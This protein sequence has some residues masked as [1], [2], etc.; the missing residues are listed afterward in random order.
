VSVAVHSKAY[1]PDIDTLRAVAVGSVL[2]FH[3][4]LPGVSGGYVGVDVF[5][6]ISGFLI[7][8]ILRDDPSIIRFYIR[9]AARI[10]PA[11]F[12]MLLVCLVVGYVILLPRDLEDLATSTLATLGFAS[13]ILFWQQSGYFATASE[14][15]PLLHTWSLAVEEQFYVLFPL[16]MLATR[17][18]ERRKVA[19]LVGILTVVSFLI[20]VYCVQTGKQTLAFFLSPTRA[21][22]LWVGSLIALGAVPRIT[23]IALRTVL[24]GGGLAL[25]L[26][27]VLTFHARTPFPG[28]AALAPVLGSA[29]VIVAG[30]DGRHHLSRFFELR[31]VLFIGLISYSLYL[32][33]WPLLAYLAYVTIDTPPL[34]LSLLAL[35]IAT[36]LATLSWR[37]VERPFRGRN[38]GK[39]QYIY[40]IGPVAFVCACIAALA[41]DGLPSRVPPE[42]A[43]LNRTNGDVVRCPILNTRPFGG[44]RACA[45][46]G[47]DSEPRH[48]DVILWGDS[49]AEM[50][51]PAIAAAV[52]P[53]K[54]V[55]ILARS[56][57]PVPGFNANVHCARDQPLNLEAI[58]KL[59]AKDVVIAF[60]WGQYSF[61][62]LWNANGQRKPAAH[63]ATLLPELTASVDALVAAGKTVTIIGPIAAP[64]FEVGS[65]S[66]REL[67]FY[68]RFIHPTAYDRQSFETLMG[69]ALTALDEMSHRP[70][71]RVLKI[72]EHLCETDRC[73][74]IINGEAI[75]ADHGHLSTRYVASLEP[76]FAS[77]L[78]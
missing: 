69:P 37:F 16:I 57:A 13:N 65:V 61:Q 38:P 62:T 23:S 3:A 32:W 18:W 47:G 51:G 77:V 56:C 33:H 5:F 9:R 7:T 8:G 24:A 2:L 17:R 29:A 67:Q 22:E 75:F 27:G 31:P 68:G 58:R 54:V 28:I 53:R 15:K 59:P 63:F 41:T 39:L 4:G 25:I 36:V 34:H 26:L 72:H 30:M 76:E 60:N 71:V 10:L 49:N 78:R 40:A 6:V 42:V 20:S 52:A 43:A 74:Y 21:W 19:I 14:I 66:A 46:L 45:P 64:G 50:Y 48:A 44:S 1:R 73:P 70:N 35:V 11:L 12:A 55:L